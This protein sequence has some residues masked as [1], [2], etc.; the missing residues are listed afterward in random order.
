VLD[1]LARTHARTHYALR[2]HGNNVCRW[3]HIFNVVAVFTVS[4]TCGVSAVP[5]ESLDVVG[6]S[7]AKKQSW[8]WHAVILSEDGDILA[9]SVIIDKR[10][11]VTVAP[12]SP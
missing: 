3:Y 4:D 7:E 1:T 11:I 10:W 12:D 9:D 6:T 5:P 8:P 2:V